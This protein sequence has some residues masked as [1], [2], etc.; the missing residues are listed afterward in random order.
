MR[1][2]RAVIRSSNCNGF[3]PSAFP[4]RGSVECLG[5]RG[6]TPLFGEA[7]RRRDQKRH[8]HVVLLLHSIGGCR[9]SDLIQVSLRQKAVLRQQANCENTE[10]RSNLEPTRKWQ[11]TPPFWSSCLSGENGCQVSKVINIKN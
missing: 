7:Q 11:V 3:Q 5:N 1:R 4:F 8:R 9:I 10:S 2:V 6:A